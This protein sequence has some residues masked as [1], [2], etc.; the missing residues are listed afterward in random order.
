GLRSYGDH[1]IAMS[2]AVLALFAK[3]PVVIHNIAC[4]D[5]SYP[6][7]WSHMEALGG[8]VG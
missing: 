8:H 6:E 3:E 4:V 2:M 7:F 5:T 1:R